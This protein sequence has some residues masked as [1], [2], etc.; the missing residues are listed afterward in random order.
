MTPRPIVIGAGVNGL[1]AAFYLARAGLKSPRPGAV[2]SGWRGREHTRAG[3]GRARPR[4][5]ACCRPDSAGHCRRDGPG[6]HGVQWLRPS[7]DSFT[8]DRDG[9]ALDAWHDPAAA[10]AAIGQFS[11]RDAAHYPQFL[12][13]LRGSI[14]WCGVC[15]AAEPLSIDDADDRRAV[16]AAPDRATLPRARTRAGVS[17]ASLGPDARRRSADRRVRD[18]AAA[19]HTRDARRLCIRTWPAI[20]RDRGSADPRGAPGLRLPSAGLRAGRTRSAGIRNGRGRHGG[21]RRD[22]VWR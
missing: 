1:G 2:G 7:V 10:A 6:S 8:P 14:G 3:P 20:G 21:R 17:R 16:E 13:E 18:R 9:R 22:P 19:R 12:R 4:S 5:D 11:A 15:A